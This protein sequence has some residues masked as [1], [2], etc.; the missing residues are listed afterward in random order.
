MSILNTIWYSSRSRRSKASSPQSPP[1]GVYLNA[2][3]L[4]LGGASLSDIY[5]VILRLRNLNSLEPS[6]SYLNYLLSSCRPYSQNGRPCSKRS[7][8]VH[9]FPNPTVI[10]PLILSR[11][12]LQGRARTRTRSGV[13]TRKCS[14]HQSSE[15]TF[16]KLWVST[17]YCISFKSLSKLFGTKCLII[18]SLPQEP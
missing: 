3:L 2:T 12:P 5:L 4:S 7:V 6:P 8:T 1:Q 17:L 15:S 18:L 14:R 10:G 9:L 11:V 13:G 16:H